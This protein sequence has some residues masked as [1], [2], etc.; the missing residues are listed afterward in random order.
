MIELIIQ[1]SNCINALK[2]LPPDSVDVVVTSP[3][4]NININYAEY[5]D[6]K[7]EHEYLMFL[8]DVFYE[9]HRVLKPKGSFFFNY[10]SKST[11]RELQTKVEY[12]LIQPFADEFPTLRFYMQNRITW[13]KSIS[14]SDTSRGHFNPINSSRF[15]NDCSEMVYHLTKNKNVE[16]DRN[17]IGV[18]YKDKSNIK[19]YNKEGKDLRCRG[20]VWF[21]PYKTVQKSKT[22]PAEYPQELPEWCI[23]LHGIKNTSLVVDPFGGSG[24]TLLACATLGI[25]GIA[26]EVDEDPCLLMKEKILNIRP[27][28]KV[29]ETQNK[30][31]IK[32]EES[33]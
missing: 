2:N 23:K 21:I 10:G 32:I 30:T 6:N 13:V 28:A 11:N 22:F 7:P 29:N 31:I 25:N 14:F 8:K 3:P 18:P 5:N 26:I 9:I 20:N 16:L 1:N 24:N 4:Y 12:L 19:R 33:K 27:D 17:A 15:L